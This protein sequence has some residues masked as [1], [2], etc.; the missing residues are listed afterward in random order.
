MVFTV[1]AFLAGRGSGLRRGRQRGR[2]G[3]AGRPRRSPAAPAAAGAGQGEAAGGGHCPW[4]SAPAAP[5]RSA[6]ARAGG[7]RCSSRLFP[8]SPTPPGRLSPS[9]QFPSHSRGLVAGERGA[10]TPLHGSREFS[11]ESEEDTGLAGCGLTQYYRPA[12]HERLP[13]GSS[14]P[15]QK[16]VRS[17]LQ[18]VLCQALSAF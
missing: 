7:A 10:E 14:H 4:C 5:A 13:C 1:G 8:R 6:A 18:A 15:V 17:R 11:L 9:P 3:V 16:L 12:G 2:R